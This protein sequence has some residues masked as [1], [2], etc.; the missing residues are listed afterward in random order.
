MAIE[1]VSQVSN[2]K[3]TSLEEGGSIRETGILPCA[4]LTALV[5]AGVIS[6]KSQN[7]KIEKNQIQP[8]SLDLRL[9][10]IAYRLRAS[11]LPG[12]QR[13]QDKL[14]HISYHEI[15]I[16]QGAVLEKGCVYLV[17]LMEHL[18]LPAHLSGITNPKSSTGR[19]DVFTRVLTEQGA[20]FD[21]IPSGY[22]G[23]LYL[24]ISPRSFSILVRAGSRL[25]QL[26]LR[27]NKNEENSLSKNSLSKNNDTA[28]L[29]LHKESPL[30]SSDDTI[31]INN[32]LALSVDLQGQKDMPV[33]YRAKRHAGLIDVDVAGALAIDDF[34]EPIIIKERGHLILDPDAF[35]IL[36]SREAV[37]I[38]ASH[39]AEMV[40]FDPMVG[41][42]RVHYAGFFD[43]GFGCDGLT[44]N[45]ARAV[46]EVRSRDVPFILEHGQIIG[47]LV[48][49]P[50]TAPA[51]ILYGAALGSNYQAQGL[52]LSKHFSD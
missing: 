3:D 27:Q 17:P 5:E 32:G 49:E 11:F 48:Y 6:T 8:A 45:G 52:R 31:N 2:K 19:I 35:Y 13:V 29:A 28:M 46:L 14:A 44:Q 21:T 4:S 39:A 23:A 36:A 26:R 41:E 34:W 42:F 30:V 25:S 7:T 47:R 9:G 20:H 51:E 10:R 50:L 43:P 15:D 33:G 18:S 37:R 40:P 12:K 1:L 38:P 24:E 22:E 16:A